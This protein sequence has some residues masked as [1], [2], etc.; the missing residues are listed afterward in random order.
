MK[1]LFL[2][3][4]VPVSQID[5]GVK[6]VVTMDPISDPVNGEPAVLGDISPLDDIA[7]Y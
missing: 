2:T 5:D 4:K 3:V 7:N 6:L 1:K